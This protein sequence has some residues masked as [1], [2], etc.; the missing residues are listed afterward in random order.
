[1]TTRLDGR[2]ALITGGANGLGAAIAAVFA[3]EGAKV[4]IAD[5]D[6]R[7]GCRRERRGHDLSAGGQAMYQP[8][9]VRDTSIVRGGSSRLPHGW[10][11]SIPSSPRP[12]SAVRRD[13]PAR[14]A[15]CSTS[16]SPIST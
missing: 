10:V 3:A 1:M 7:R 8:M 12:G 11:A 9:D 6:H 14:S 2:R 5:L 15:R 13:K 16:T 4:V